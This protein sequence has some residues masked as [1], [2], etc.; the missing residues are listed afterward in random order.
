MLLRRR[1]TALGARAARKSPCVS[2]RRFVL[3]SKRLYAAVILICVTVG[4]SV[5]DNAA[6]PGAVANK[7]LHAAPSRAG[8]NDEQLETAVGPQ[9]EVFCAKCHAL[10][11][12]SDAPREAWR[13]EVEQ[14]YRFH[15]T[16]PL[17]NE[18]APDREAVVAYFE[19]KAIPYDD[20]SI[21]SSGDSAPDRLRFR[22]TELRVGAESIPPAVA[23]LSWA[24]LAT[25][26]PRTL[27]VS[28]MRSG[29][30]YSI[31]PDGEL[32]VLVQ[33]GSQTLANPCRAEPC[34]LDGNG[35]VDLVVADLGNFLP[36]DLRLGRV[37]CLQQQ[38]GE[39]E[40]QSL[41]LAAG[42]GRVADVRPGDFDGDGRQDVLVA[43]F[44]WFEAGQ[45][46]LLK[47]QSVEAG[48]PK[49]EAREV[50][51]RHGTI[52]VPPTDLDG[53]GT[54]DFVA[55]ISQEHEVIEAFLNRGDGTF[56]TRRIYAAPNPSWG[57]SG[58]ELVDL[59]TDGD[60]DLLVTNGDGD[61]RYYIKPYHS[62][63]WLENRGEFPWVPHPLLAMPGCR[64][65]AASDMDGDGDLDV[66]AV[67]MLLPQILKRFGK[68]RF[69]AVCW[70][71]QTEPGHFERRPLELGTCDHLALVVADL[72]EDGDSD[73]AVG[74]CYM[75]GHDGGGQQSSVTI[76][77][78]ETERTVSEVSRR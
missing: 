46:L 41:E 64:R 57:S 17:A 47:N 52:H 30:L 43:V 10:P 24:Q 6:G 15:Q 38:P 27:L 2:L 22:R 65:A 39:G 37:I 42:I 76:W 36:T 29:G 73:M 9:V 45:I 56:E 12:A 11:R 35:L 71:E 54:L 68:D 7:P 77:W 19:R 3:S 59:D 70:L 78:N 51:N 13:H 21:K 20:Y 28:D 60:L 40:R 55:L 63:Q 62:V 48:K 69:D 1:S 49:F 44:G 18:P 8:L 75:D 33:P 5:E 74:N 67:A 53:N 58:I 50:D 34:D 66:V 31:R 14:A 25:G 72:D 61:D 4:C 32:A 26:D 16:S 23:G